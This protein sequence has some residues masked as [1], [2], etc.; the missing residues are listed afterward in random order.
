MGEEDK[1]VILSIAAQIRLTDDSER[2]H[3]KIIAHRKKA[4]G[5]MRQYKEHTDRYYRRNM[6]EA[7]FL[8]ETIS[9]ETLPRVCRII[10]SLI[11][12]IEP[13]GCSLTD[14]LQVVVLGEAIPLYVSESRDKVDHVLTK[15]EYMQ[16]LSYEEDRHRYSWRSKPNIKKY[17]HPYN[18]MIRFCAG[19]SKE[20]RDCSSYRVEEKIGDIMLELYEAANVLREKRIAKEEAERIRQEAERIR[21]EAERQEAIRREERRARY[22]AEVNLTLAL[23]NSADDY[24]IACKIRQYIA[25]VETT[26]NANMEWIKWAKEKADWYD[27][28]ISRDDSTL[29]KRNHEADD[30]HKELKPR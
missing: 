11:K 10:D 20:F 26:Q 28:T 2:M 9:E 27:P 15:D 19:Y 12:E 23:K 17:D 5:W 14:D 13:L 16:L 25:A 6:P 29:G 30:A 18:G 24:D 22:N 7:P 4:L 8:A 1:A 3:P 21:R